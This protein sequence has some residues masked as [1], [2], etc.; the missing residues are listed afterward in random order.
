M[1]K[2]IDFS[3]TYLG[4]ELGSTRIKATVIDENFKVIASGSHNWENRFENGYWTYS[5]DDIH[6]GVQSCYADLKKTIISKFG[7]CPTLYGAIGVSAMMHGYMAFDDDSNLLTPFRTWRNTTTKQAADELSKLFDFNIPQ[8]WSIAHLYQAMLNG[9]EHIGKINRISTLA[10]YIHYLLTNRHEVGVCEA[11]GMFPVKSGTYDRHMLEKF[12][13]ISQKYG[14][15]KNLE[16]VLPCICT[17]GENKAHLTE[18]GAKFLDPSGSLCADIPIC[19]PEGDAAT[20]MVATNSVRPG[21][22]NI[23]AG[24][25]VFAM[26]VLENEPKGTHREIDIVTTPQGKPVA[27]VHC[28]NCC[29][30]LDNWVNVFA[31]FADL[32]GQ[33]IDKS[34]LYR[35]LYENALCGDDDCGGI[36]AYN[37][38]SSE[39]TV[40]VESGKPMYFRTQNSNFTL[41]NFIKAQLYSSIAALKYGM[42]ILF[43]SENV[44]ATAFFAHGGLFKV[45]GVAQQFL[46]NALSTPVCITENSGEGGAYGM[47]LL[48]A[49][50]QIGNGLLLDDWLDNAVFCNAK[51]VT[52]MPQ[53]NGASGFCEFMRR[54]KVGIKA[55]KVLSEV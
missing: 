51:T 8:R 39:P 26:L 19:P 5:L 10:G 50:M 1:N 3:K 29:G 30:E 45:K 48:A 12:D 20:G 6:V 37:Y 28:N 23:S 53:P 11:S 43:D 54:Y 24:T 52:A 4:I 15:N 27:M 7:V 55:H 32:S 25:S 40:G 44:N 36:I 17:A 47:A 31:E 49:Y 13:D 9:E 41:A 35:M 33:H 46:A 16:D 42:D 14:F 2:N 22:G 34:D 18:S 38:I 21:T